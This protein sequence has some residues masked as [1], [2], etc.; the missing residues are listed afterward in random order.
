MTTYIRV[1]IKGFKN[2]KKITLNDKKIKKG[3]LRCYI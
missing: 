1:K 2:D 3:V